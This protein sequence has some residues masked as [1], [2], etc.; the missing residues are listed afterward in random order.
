MAQ[1]NITIGA[2]DAGEG[3]DYFTAFTK[4]QANF[5]DLY[6][7]NS[8]NTEVI[9][10]QESDF[11]VQDGSAITLQ[12]TTSYIIS[13]ALTT[14]K[15]FIVENGSLITA[16]NQFGPLLT[17]SGT[18][19]MF[20]GTDATF[21][22][23]EIQFT[24]PTA[25]QIFNFNDTIGGAR[26]FI[27]RNFFCLSAVK[28]GTFDSMLTFFTTGSSCIDIDDGITF[29]GTNQTLVS[30][31]QC[32]LLSTSATFTG[33][34]L[35]TTVISDI[36]FNDLLLVAPA[37]GVGISGLTA[38]GNVPAN[39]L[40]MVN[41]S[42]FSG[43]MTPLSGI[44]N[45]D[46]RWRFFSNSGISN[47]VFDGMLSLNGNATETVIAATDT[48]VL[49]LGTWVVE[50]ASLFT[51][52]TAGRLTSDAEQ[53]IVTPIDATLTIN[54]ASGTNKDIHAYIAVNGTVVANS[55]KGNRVGATDPRNT[56]LVWQESLDG[57]DYVETYIE[58]N[59][60]TVN[61]VTSDA[62]LRLN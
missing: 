9:I 43:G 62:V 34:D 56:S 16:R 47:T 42:S 50:R 10:T 12:A 59:S 19:A 4:T 14:A 39:F 33:I 35:G 25:S 1:Q 2:A 53:S 55:G 6:A 17:Y 21:T 15:R 41:N 24:C 37:G 31:N 26:L 13:A 32:A 11:P 5:T 29:T 20:T 23:A 51:G 60:D 30:Y 40:A 27:G 8:A 38:S 18:L 61:L 28:F 3:D 46:I 57:G 36:E 44:T 45:E 52:T 22:I 54:S 58:N 49:V 7:V 48:P